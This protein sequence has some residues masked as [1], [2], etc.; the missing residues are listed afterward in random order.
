MKLRQLELFKETINQGLNISAAAESLHTSQP[1]ISKQ[2]HELADEL[3]VELFQYS[4]KR[5]VG[6]T[7][8]G[9]AIARV[10]D[11]VLS[12]V[13]RIEAIAADQ[14]KG[15]AGRIVVATSRYGAHHSLADTIQRFATDHPDCDLVIHEDSTR[16]ITRMV[17]CGDADLGRHVIHQEVAGIRSQR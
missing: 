6:L 11:E 15:E 14:Q 7:T 8:T 2:L 10:T 3:G 12:G 1:S 16:A 17:A 5:L 13:K 4:G 9:E